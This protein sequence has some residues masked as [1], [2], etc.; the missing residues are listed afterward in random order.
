MGKLF[1]SYWI[2]LVGGG[3]YFPVL[4][5]ATKFKQTEFLPT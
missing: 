2:W 3:V 1:G 5:I 4:F